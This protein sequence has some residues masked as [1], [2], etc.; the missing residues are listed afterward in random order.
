MR[1]VGP[2][3]AGGICGLWENFC[4]TFKPLMTVWAF[5][6]SFF[7]SSGIKSKEGTRERLCG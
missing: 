5:R 4:P 6:K 3:R 1:G 7:Q 2:G